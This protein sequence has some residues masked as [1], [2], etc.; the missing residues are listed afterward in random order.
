[1]PQLKYEQIA[2]DLRTRMA[3]GEFGPGDPLPSGR[4]LAEQWA[5]SRATVVKAYDTLRADGLVVARQGSG[6]TVVETP[7]ARPAGGRRAGSTRIA[8]GA[9]YRRL[10]TPD[11][12]A[13][14]PH[15]ADA[16][17]LKP[18]VEA[19][20]RVRVVLLDDGDAGTLV[21][22]WFPPSVADAA[23]RL[24][25]RGPIREGTTHYVRRETGRRPVEGIDILTVRL[26]TAEEAEVLGIDLPAAVAVLLH[27]AIDQGHRPLVCEEGITAAAV[28]EAVERYPM[29]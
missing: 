16:L 25:E 23:P 10:G 6:F 2:E 27:T 15:V 28:F 3:D 20:R 9:P 14:P 18:G 17:G 8:G 13:P 5:V 19:L 22:A 1:M 21:T 26:A 12:I 29:E 24:A 4:D 11:R 7:V